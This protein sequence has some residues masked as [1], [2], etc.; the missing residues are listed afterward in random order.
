MTPQHHAPG[1]RRYA[2]G[3]GSR[4]RSVNSP[5]R[6]TGHFVECPADQS[7]AGEFAVNFIDSEGQNRA[8]SNV[9]SAEA[10]AEGSELGSVIEFHDMLNPFWT[11]KHV[12]FLF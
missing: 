3:K 12:L 7:A 4:R 6:A 10:G 8:V 1:S 11:V 2:R 9:S 5:I